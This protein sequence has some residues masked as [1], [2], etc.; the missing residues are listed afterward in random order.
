MPDAFAFEQRAASATS[1]SA[2]R[3]PAAV[4][5]EW[6][7]PIPGKFPGDTPPEQMSAVGHI[8][9][10]RQGDVASRQEVQQVADGAFPAGGFR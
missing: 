5:G 4:F 7:T 1:Q 10:G 2:D 8:V 9:L 3:R 6:P